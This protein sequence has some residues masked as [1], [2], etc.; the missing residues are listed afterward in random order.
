[1]LNPTRP[2]R[3]PKRSWFRP[4]VYHVVTPAAGDVS[5]GTFFELADPELPF[6]G[7]GEATDRSP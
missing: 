4:R 7:S 3:Q 6:P 2:D 1:M 5:G